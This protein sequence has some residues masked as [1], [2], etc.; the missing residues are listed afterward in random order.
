MSRIAALPDELSAGQL[1]KL[2]PLDRRIERPV[3]VVEG[4]LIAEAGRLFAL[5]NQALLPDVEFIL[6]D[7]FQELFVRQLMRTSFLQAQF[8]TG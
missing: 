3:E 8:Q 6:K 1:I 5:I 2:L 7:Q 4:F